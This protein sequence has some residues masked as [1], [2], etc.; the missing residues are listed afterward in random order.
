MTDLSV[1]GATTNSVSNANRSVEV[2]N[3]NKELCHIAFQELENKNSIIVP[4]NIPSKIS[5]IELCLAIEKNPFGYEPKDMKKIAKLIKC[6]VKDFGVIWKQ[7]VLSGLL[8]DY[9]FCIIENA[10]KTFV[11]ALEI[12]AILSKHNVTNEEFQKNIYR[13][14]L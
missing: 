8:F 14:K 9:K 7:I 12:N 13:F 5:I 6:P 11:F 2:W 10:K 1:V 4:T 3:N